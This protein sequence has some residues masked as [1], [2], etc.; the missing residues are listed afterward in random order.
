M[1]TTRVKKTRRA[2]RVP[3]VGRLWR[4]GQSGNP[5]GRPKG[6][7]NKSSGGVRERCQALIG[8]PQHQAWL[9]REFTRRVGPEHTLLALVYAYAY[10]RPVQA[11][12]LQSTFDPKAWLGRTEEAPSD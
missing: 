8:L 4:T 7:R 11:I 2:L 6:A 1:G 5:A 9:R 12:D 10:G 3:P